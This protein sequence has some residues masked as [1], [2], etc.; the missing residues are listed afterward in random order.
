MTCLYI[1]GTLINREKN[2]KNITICDT[3]SIN[4]YRNYLNKHLYSMPR[5]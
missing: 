3:T 4:N 2:I 5:Q 1:M